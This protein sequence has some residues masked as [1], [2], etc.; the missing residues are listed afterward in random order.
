M[1]FS[2]KDII[3]NLRND[4]EQG[5]RQLFEKYYRPLVLFAADYLGDPAVAEDLVQ[6]VF[7]KLWNKKNLI[8]ITPS[9][10]PSY[11]YTSV[12]NECL[13]YLRKNK[14]FHRSTYSA[15]NTRLPNSEAGEV[16]EDVLDYVYME[17]DK[18]APRSKTAI[19]CIFLKGMKYKEAAEYMGITV[20][21]LKSLLKDGIR[22]LRENTR[23][24]TDLYGVLLI[25]YLLAEFLTATFS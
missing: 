16:G 15:E 3:D 12:R 8:G 7:V 19:Q 14:V 11:I 13:M 20:N 24:L 17:L 22:K 25:S 4:E 5:I 10:L 6:N 2:D 21:T 23:H 9:A 1:Y 18:L